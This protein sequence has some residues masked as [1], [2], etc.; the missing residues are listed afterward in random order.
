MHEAQPTKRWTRHKKN[1][2]IASTINKNCSLIPENAWHAAL[3]DI[4]AVEQTHHKSN[5]YGKGLTLVEVIERYVLNNAQ[6]LIEYLSSN[7]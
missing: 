6:L 5:A 7:S 1:Q 2:V 3:K 4:N